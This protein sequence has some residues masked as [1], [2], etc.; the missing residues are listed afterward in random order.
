MSKK[1]QR[2]FSRKVNTRQKKQ[3]FLIVCQGEQTEKNYFNS[4][5]LTSAA[6]KVVP[7]KIDP[8]S[9]VKKAI[10][11]NKND[12]INKKGGFDQIWCVF[13][14]DYYTEKNIED[15]LS[16]KKVR[17]AFSTPEDALLK[18][19][20]RTA[21]STPCF[22]LWFLLHFTHFESE[23]ETKVLIGEKLPEHLTD[24]KKNE[25]GIYDKILKKQ[26]VAIENAKKLSSPGNPSTTVYKLVEELNKFLN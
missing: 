13:D 17:T 4:F 23:V 26:G 21:F 6:V 7:E 5:R 25:K 20:V 3:R 18:K 15:A 8:K 9:L 24:Y 2:N 22:E 12:K 11:I 10:E 19:K 16:E 14:K 1:A